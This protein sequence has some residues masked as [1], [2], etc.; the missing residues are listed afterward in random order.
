[1]GPRGPFQVFVLVRPNESYPYAI[2]VPRVRLWLLIFPGRTVS[3][4]YV[5]PTS[6]AVFDTTRPSA[7]YLVVVSCPP[8]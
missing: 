1:M 3:Q 4:V 5:S 6:G 7:S 8:M 2:D